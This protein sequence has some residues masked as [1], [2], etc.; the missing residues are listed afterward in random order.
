MIGRFIG[1]K[2]GNYALLTV[3]TMVPLMG[4]VALAVDFTEL[5]REKQETLNALDAAGVATAQQIVSGA[6][7][8]DAKAYAKQFF[9]ANLRHVS[10][11]NTTLTV[12][13]PNNNA[14]GGTLVLDAS[15]KYH[16]YFLPAAAMLL[17]GTAGDHVVNVSARSEIR[18]KNTLEVA[19]VLDN[20]GSMS[21]LGSGTGQKR[22][23]LL[24]AAAK[25]LVKTLALQ[26]QQMKQ[27]S[28]PV[29]F[30]LVPFSASV[31]VG[32]T[33]DGDSWMDQD[34]ISP[35][36]HENFDWTTMSA[37]NDRNKYAE[38]VNGAWYKRGDGW[39]D[40]KDQPLTRFSLYSDM[41]VESDRETVQP[42]KQYV[43]DVTKRDG[44]CSKGHWVTPAPTYVYTTSRYASWQGCVE[45]RPYPYNDDDTTP[46]TSNPATL[47][48]PMFA[49]DEAGTLW[50]DFDRDGSN[51]VSAWPISGSYYDNNWWADWPY[52]PTNPTAKQRQSDMRKYFLVKP[53]GSKSAA[54]GDG[55]NAGCTTSPIT[56]L[57]DVTVSAQKQELDDAIDE[58][59]PTGN[60]NVPEGLA[61]GWRTVS[62]NEPFTEGR[63]N[64]EKGNDKVVIVLTDGANTY[65]P[66][67]DASY[68]NNR[69]T[70]A[71]YGYTGLTYPG[72]GSVTRL[73]MNTSTAVPKTTYTDGNYTAALDEQMQTLC[74]N[75][76]A[77]GIMVMTVSLDLVDTKAD[78]KK[79]MA[80]LKACASDSRFRRDPADPSK[81][82][83]LF[84]N[85]TGATLSD[86]F[87]A[88]G[89]ELS[90]LRIVS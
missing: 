52:D 59:A 27:I 28:K 54:A 1:D 55:P 62:S 19:L 46:T 12:T 88:I 76:K 48:V 51:D 45:A 21:T 34:G 74:A 49:P 42:P 73:F 9:E 44:T 39:G 82:A 50:R 89:N 61:W 10:P 11:A 86:D 66:F 71:A 65:S 72:S 7:D 85:S 57:K 35:V 25:Q 83:K 43:C 8:A 75:A 90:N 6:S 84:W 67:S 32:P 70:Y 30:S 56:P 53:Y 41:T 63:P 3:V 78:E 20:S 37:D 40:T 47:F 5:V 24:K 79:A 68:A 26:A 22:I 33:H 4:A 14:G 60:T 13:L 36:Q 77:A 2:R 58:M 81:P 69:S 31:N 80:A 29:Q 87:K 38:K 18:L 23:D 15:L 16:P 17:G 64:N